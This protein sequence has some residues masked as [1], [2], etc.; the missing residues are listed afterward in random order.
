MIERIHLRVVHA[1]KQHGS[2]TA[3]AGVLCVT[4]SA[5]SHKCSSLMGAYQGL[6]SRRLYRDFS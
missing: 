6:S 3:A 2:L 4:Q 1:V 5:L